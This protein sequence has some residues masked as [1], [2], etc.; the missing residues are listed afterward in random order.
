MRRVL[1]EEQ[2]G[3]R[4]PRSRRAAALEHHGLRDFQTSSTGM[5]AMGSSGRLGRGVDDVVGA[6][7]QHDVG[8]G[9]VLVDLV[10]LEHDVVGH[11]GL[12]EQHVHVARQAARDG[13]DGE[14]HSAPRLAQQLGDL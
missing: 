4:R 8:V 14:A 10:H 3:S 9:E 13:V 11:V 6:D 7:D 2:A 5:P 1:F 12:G